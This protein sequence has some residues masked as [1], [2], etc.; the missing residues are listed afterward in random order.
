[1]CVPTEQRGGRAGRQQNLLRKHGEGV[2]SSA[3]KESKPYDSERALQ[4][5]RGV[6]RSMVTVVASGAAAAPRRHRGP[7][8]GSARN[9]PPRSQQPNTARVY[10]AA[11]FRVTTA[12]VSKVVAARDPEPGTRRR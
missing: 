3:G 7:R 4:S 2:R 5:R 8:A 6:A 12:A 10:A 11:Q 1:M 9:P